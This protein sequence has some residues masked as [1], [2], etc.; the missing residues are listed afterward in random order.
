ME[1]GITAIILTKDEELNIAECIESIKNV[2]SRIV[3]VDSFST[4]QTVDIAKKHGAEVLLHEF[5][6]HSKQYRYGEREAHIKTEWTLRI[7]AD[8][9][10]ST[11]AAR[12]IEEILKK[13]DS[14]ITG[15]II[16]FTVE[17]MGRKLK[18]GGMYPFKKLLLYKTGKGEIE[19]R[20]MD[21]HIVLHEGKAIELK[22]DSYHH[23][24]KDLT[25]WIEKHNKYASREVLDYYR[26]LT[27]E[28]HETGK[29]LS[30]NAKFKRWVK[31]NIYYKLPMGAR[32]HFYYIYRYYFK[33]GF[34]DG[35]EGKIYCFFQAYWYRYLVDAKIYESEKMR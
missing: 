35:K 8:E 29:A 2:V 16:R 32:A 9:R 34:L 25:R 30:G 15:V 14:D 18:H 31:F 5:E 21:E 3:L 26:N 23:D 33:R 19:D 1:K 4:E 12:E 11:E 6:N 20:A 10:I 22:N 13:D 17:F 28:V 7:D 24:Y 27:G